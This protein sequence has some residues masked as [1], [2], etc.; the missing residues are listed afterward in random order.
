MLGCSEAK[1]N[2]DEPDAE[3]VQNKTEN[4]TGHEE[5]EEDTGANKMNMYF[6]EDDNRVAN[7]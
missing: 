6:P 4:D 3:N 5:T 2:I 7:S 1:I